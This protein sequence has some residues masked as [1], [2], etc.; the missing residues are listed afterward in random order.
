MYD[1]LGTFIETVLD[2]ASLPFQ[3]IFFAT[4]FSRF[5]HNVFII[6]SIIYSYLSSSSI[7]LNAVSHNNEV[8]ILYS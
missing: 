5:H 1:L 2:Y 7:H 6:I 4:S 3:L 8:D